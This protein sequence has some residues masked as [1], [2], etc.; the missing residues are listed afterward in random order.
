VSRAWSAILDG[1]LRERAGTLAA[2]LARVIA[3]PARH[4]DA[5][6]AH[7]MAGAALCLGHVADGGDLLDAAALLLGEAIERAPALPLRL[8]DGSIGVAWVIEHLQRTLRWSEDD[9]NTALDDVVLDYVAQPTW[10]APWGWWDGL[11][12]LAGFLVER[13]PAVP[14]ARPSLERAVVHFLDGAH[15]STGLGATW[16][17]ARGHI[18]P[19]LGHAW[20][21]YDLIG[22]AG[23]LAVLADI[24][25]AGIARAE[26]RGLLLRGFDWLWNKRTPHGLPR[27]LGP[28]VTI[29]LA[30]PCWD[31]SLGAGAALLRAADA[32]GDPDR[33]AEVEA[34]LVDLAR[35]PLAL[36]DDVTLISG[37]A[38]AGHTYARLFQRTGQAVF[39]ERAHA[40]YAHALEHAPRVPD[41][42]LASGLA[43]VVLAL[44]AAA[45]AREPSWDRV[46]L[47]SG[48]EAV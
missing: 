36:T 38:G 40:H 2:E 43:G 42:G 6:L 35:A 13:L 25:A 33:V 22:I 30:A 48:A 8:G 21:H 7:G 37:S 18:A 28:G 9:P 19:G 20:G 1:A 12:G 46:L 34:W 10:R 29:E 44:H 16:W 14:D 31:G 24:H 4:R 23:V 15:T 3:A 45:S 27:F 39:A 41:L 5:S 17:T 26:V 32:L 47:L 11:A